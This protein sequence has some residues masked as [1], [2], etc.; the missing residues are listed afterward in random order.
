MKRFIVLQILLAAI[1][2]AGSGAAIGGGHDGG[3]GPKAS[4]DG[5]CNYTQ[6]NMFA[7]PFKV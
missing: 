5:H 3:G 1:A 6:E 7:G 4:G 2:L